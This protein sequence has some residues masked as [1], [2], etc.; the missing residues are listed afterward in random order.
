M[1][2]T[3]DIKKRRNS[4]DL[5]T[6]IFGKVPPQAKELEEVILG[7]LMLDANAVFIGM[8]RLFPEI[9]YVESHQRIFKAIQQLYDK[10]NKI[11][12]LTVIEELKKNEDLDV[13]GGMYYV[14]KLT[15]SV[16]SGA[17]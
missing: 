5:G 8:S 11:D 7:G 15:N 13:V 12:I 6:M 9:F 4:V 17:N 10:G 2:Y 1:D 16:I 3:T 14:S